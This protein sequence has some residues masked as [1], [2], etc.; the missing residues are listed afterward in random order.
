[1]YE[2]EDLCEYTKRPLI[3]M[4]FFKQTIKFLNFFRF[5]FFLNIIFRSN[6]CFQLLIFLQLNYE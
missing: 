3:T 4:V 6:I 5:T 2:A 1:M